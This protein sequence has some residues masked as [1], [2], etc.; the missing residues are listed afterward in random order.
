MLNQIFEEQYHV[1]EGCYYGLFIDSNPDKPDYFEIAWNVG[2]DNSSDNRVY[3]ICYT[4]KDAVKIY[5]DCT[6]FY[7]QFLST[8]NGISG[9]NIT[10]TIY[11]PD[12]IKDIEKLRVW[13]HGSLYGE[14]QKKILVQ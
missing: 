14:I 11:L 7:W 1:D 4:V 10:G 13:A 6:E 5:N 12:G 3:Q 8:E 9:E 2:L